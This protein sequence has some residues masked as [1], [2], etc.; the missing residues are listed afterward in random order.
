LLLD[1]SGT[2]FGITEFGGGGAGALIR[3]GTA[4]SITP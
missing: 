2:L 4:F 1:P 3:G